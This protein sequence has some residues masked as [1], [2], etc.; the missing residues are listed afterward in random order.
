MAKVIVVGGRENPEKPNMGQYLVNALLSLG[1][2]IVCV[3]T[4]SAVYRPTKAGW[5]LQDIFFRTELRDGCC[6][7]R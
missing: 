4:S 3:R 2:E 5:K 7:A 1:I 6:G